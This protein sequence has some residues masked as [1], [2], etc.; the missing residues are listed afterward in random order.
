MAFCS[1][2]G[3][4]FAEG[5]KFC[6][7]CGAN[8]D[9]TVEA[10]TPHCSQCGVELVEGTKFCSGCGFKTDM[11]VAIPA[12]VVQEQSQPVQSPKPVGQIEC[13]YCHSSASEEEEGCQYGQG[14][15]CS[16]NWGNLTDWN[17]TS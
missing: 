16:S 5:V 4:E 6:S 9:G 8:L 11:E 12:A 2:C 1:E 10:V 14:N 7:G 15:G 3:G 17:W 13:P